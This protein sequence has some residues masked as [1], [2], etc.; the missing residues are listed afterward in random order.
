MPLS[1]V[2]EDLSASPLTREHLQADLHAVNS[3]KDIIRQTRGGSWPETD[4]EEDFNFLDLA[5]HEREFRDGDSFAY[6][7]YK[8]DEYVGCFYLYPMGERTEITP[9]LEQYDVDLSWWVTEP[10]YKQ[11]YYRK[12]MSALDAWIKAFPFKHVHKSNAEL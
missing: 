7:V 9:E 6:V 8:G 10:M 2:Y 11:G 12:L 5:W 1:L 4:L 3:S